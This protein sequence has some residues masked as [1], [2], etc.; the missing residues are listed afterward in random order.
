MSYSWQDVASPGAAASGSS[1]AVNCT[2]AALTKTHLHVFVAGAEVTPTAVTGSTGAWVVSVPGPINAGETVRFQRVTPRTAAGQLVNFAPGALDVTDLNTAF[3]QL[4]Y[5]AQEDADAA[6]RAVAAQIPTD[7]GGSGYDYERGATAKGRTITDLGAPSNPSDAARLSDVQAVALNTGNLPNVSTAP[8][9][10]CLM[11]SSGAWAVKTSAAV[12]NGLGLKTAALVDTGTGASQVPLTSQ[13]D[14]RYN[15]LGNNLSDVP[16]KAVARSNMGLGTAAVRNTGTSVNEIPLLA[17][18]GQMPA[19]GGANLAM[20]G[21]RVYGRNGGMLDVVVP[22][23]FTVNSAVQVDATGGWA[24]TNANRI[25]IAG[26]G[27]ALN[28]GSADVGAASPTVSLANGTYLV[29]FSMTLQNQSGATRTLKY[30]VVMGTGIAGGS[31]LASDA[32]GWSLVSNGV[33]AVTKSDCITVTGGP[34][35]LDLKVVA[36]AGSAGD[37]KVLDACLLFQKVG[38]P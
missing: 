11:V 12:R 15:Q 36:T 5:I 38:D 27:T 20:S 32:A 23:Q 14:A 31:I 26:L 13:A 9:A 30:A 24:A 2:L 34:R 33:F 17:A 16:D 19:V 4:L 25:A 6:E 1:V 29:T 22:V 18:S 35:T 7:D 21:N 10:S 8:D 37:L 28:N 3:L